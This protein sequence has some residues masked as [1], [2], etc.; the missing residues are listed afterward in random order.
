MNYEDAKNAQ[1]TFFRQGRLFN[2]HQEHDNIGEW[3][4]MPTDD[5][6]AVEESVTRNAIAEVKRLPARLRVLPGGKP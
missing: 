1:A 2:L 6:K 3:Y 4:L 5:R